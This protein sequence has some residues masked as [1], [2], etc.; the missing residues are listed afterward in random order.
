M[1]VH[2]ITMNLK[3]RKQRKLILPIRLKLYFPL[4]K[5]GTTSPSRPSTRLQEQ[6][7]TLE[8]APHPA[9]NPRA[10]SQ[11]SHNFPCPGPRPDPC[12]LCPAIVYKVRPGV[13]VYS[14]LLSPSGI[15]I[16]NCLSSTACQRHKFLGPDGCLKNILPF[17]VA[18]G[19]L[20]QPYPPTEP[21]GSNKGTT[22]SP[23]PVGQSSPTLPK[24]LWVFLFPAFCRVY[25]DS[26]C[27]HCPTRL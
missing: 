24:F 19:A 21:L 11:H 3:K 4:S 27:G 9:C 15:Q 12:C 5:A 10:G 23:R 14:L 7:I 22:S 25:P 20:S 13:S 6:C 1:Y 8:R 16:A 18:R 26:W 2:L 17:R